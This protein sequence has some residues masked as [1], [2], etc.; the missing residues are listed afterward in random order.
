MLADRIML[1]FERL[2]PSADS[3][4]YR[5]TQLDCLVWPQWERKCLAT[6]RLEVSGREYTL[7]S[8][9]TQRSREWEIEEGL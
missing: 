1:S 4:I 9:S 2:H 6:Q 8:P 3:D 5:H 7:G